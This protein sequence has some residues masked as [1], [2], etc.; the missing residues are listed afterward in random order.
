MAGIIKAGS[1]LPAGFVSSGNSPAWEEVDDSY[2]GKIRQEAAAVIAQA[3]A[4]A[5]QIRR[6]AMEEGKRAAMEATEAML[7][8]KIEQQ[9]QSVVQALKAAIQSILAAREQWQR[10]W[11]QH[12]LQLSS[13]IAA[14]ICRR[15]VEKVPLITVDLVREALQLA[16]GNQRVTLRVN[17]TDFTSLKPHIEQM[18]A[19]LASVSDTRVIADPAITTGGCRVDTEF[20]SIDQQFEAQLARIL[21]ELD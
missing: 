16:A 10:H 13:A 6:T 3:Q 17:P 18:I 4:Q 7:R 5:E 11:E 14:R 20:G 21:E 2:L 19:Q 8:A 1:A 9:L 15:E 12:A